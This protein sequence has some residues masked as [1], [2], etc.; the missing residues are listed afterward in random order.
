MI[1]KCESI[2]PTD[3]DG[4]EIFDYTADM[5]LSSS[6]AVIRVMPGI[7]HALSRSTRSDKYYFVV[8]GAVHFNI[9]GK[10][11]LLCDGDACVVLKGKQFWYENKSEEPVKLILFHTPSFRIEAEVFED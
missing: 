3:F 9:D 4:L 8:D 10:D 11:A 5:E 7:R 6:L 2:K 1:R